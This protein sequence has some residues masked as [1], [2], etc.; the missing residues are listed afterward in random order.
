MQLSVAK[1]ET[2]FQRTWSELSTHPLPCG[3]AGL[4]RAGGAAREASPR[5]PG[6][7]PRWTLSAAKEPHYPAASQGPLP[8]QPWAHCGQKEGTSCTLAGE[9]LS[10]KPEHLRRMTGRPQLQQPQNSSSAFWQQQNRKAALMSPSI[11]CST[12]YRPDS[13]ST[14]AN[15]GFCELPFQ[16][17]LE[18]WLQCAL[19]SR[20]WPGIQWYLLKDKLLKSRL[21]ST[22]VHK[23]KCKKEGFFFSAFGSCQDT[24]MKNNIFFPH[25]RYP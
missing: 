3:V 20:Y 15:S 2:A 9:C 17:A 21:V 13:S 18:K 14:S 11:S 25:E 12:V 8:G 24:N 16:L 1:S 23:R 5:C 4:Q 10:P 6:P 22:Q 19:R 7:K